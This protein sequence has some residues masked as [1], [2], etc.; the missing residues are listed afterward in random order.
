MIDRS[1][2]LRVRAFNRSLAG[3]ILVVL[4]WVSIWIGAS[5]DA[6][7][8]YEIEVG[9]DHYDVTATGSGEAFTAIDP[10]LTYTT[11]WWSQGEQTARNFAEAYWNTLGKTVLPFTETGNQALAFAYLLSSTEV[12][13]I[14]VDEDLGVV[15]SAQQY[16]ADTGTANLWWAVGSAVPVPEING[17]S[18]SMAL[19][20]IAALGTFLAVRRQR[21]GLAGRRVVVLAHSCTVFAAGDEAVKKSPVRG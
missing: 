2:S 10:S 19:F 4:L 9:G 1:T 14:L 3:S 11:P 5:A 13:A 17:N 18:L 15:S 7:R 6:G 21:H 12:S 20:C 16:D 8:A